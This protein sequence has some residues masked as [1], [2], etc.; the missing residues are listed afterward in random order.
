[1]IEG[2]NSKLE[3]LQNQNRLKASRDKTRLKSVVISTKQLQM[4]QAAEKA[5]KD[6]SE[7]E[8]ALQ[9]RWKK[10][11]DLM[12]KE[13][14]EA[15]NRKREHDLLLESA[16][17]DIEQKR[18]QR[19][20]T[21]MQNSVPIPNLTE[22]SNAT[23]NIPNQRNDLS[24]TS[25]LPSP[26]PSPL[27][28]T[29]ASSSTIDVDSV[30]VSSNR[31]NS[32][33]DVS[34]E[35]NTR[36]SLKN[37]STSIIPIAGIVLKTIDKKTNKKV[38]VNVIHHSDIKYDTSTLVRQGDYQSLIYVCELGETL[39][40][41]GSVSI[42]VDV[43]LYTNYYHALVENQ[44]ELCSL[45]IDK[46]I[47]ITGLE[48]DYDFKLPRIMGNY[49]V[50]SKNNSPPSILLPLSITVF[51]N[52]KP[53]NIKNDISNSKKVEQPIN[54]ATPA[55]QREWDFLLMMARTLLLLV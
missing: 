42:V 3:A 1:M 13:A 44:N 10:Q 50:S 24:T 45:V 19:R 43:I 35:N 23:T 21:I 25:T 18:D 31:E 46:V 37:E 5:A 48:L 6:R 41:S 40:Q 53:V 27:P 26:N 20:F 33:D 32:S 30:Q 52:R 7:L 55:E 16:L 2:E 15:A 54:F 49:K 9:Q 34:S 38:F 17:S 36:E 11:S 4:E 47:S 39:D 12:E 8:S 28:T 14:E 29:P 22:I 51:D